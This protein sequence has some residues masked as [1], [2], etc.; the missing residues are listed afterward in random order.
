MLAPSGDSLRFQL[1]GISMYHASD[2]ASPE[3]AS[4]EEPVPRRCCHRYLVVLAATFVFVTTTTLAAQVELQDPDVAVFAKA[5]EWI[6]RH[7]EFYADHYREQTKQAIE[8][9]EKRTELLRQGKTPW[10]SQIGM[11]V[12]GYRSKVD[13]SIQPFAVTLP[14]GFDATSD[15]SWPLHVVLHGRA[16]KMN[17]VNFIHQYNDKPVS[18]ENTGWIQLDVFGRTNNAYRWSGETD[19]FEAIAKVKTLYRID[20]DRIVLRGFSMGGAGAWHLGM[21]HPHVWCSVGPGAGFVDFYKYQ[22]Q[23]KPLPTHQHATL[24]IYDSIDYALNAFNVP[25]CTYGGEND[26]QL[27]AGKSMHDAAMKLGVPMKLIVGPNMGH[28]FDPESRREFIEFHTNAMRAGRT[29]GRNR[30]EIRFT[31]RTLRY[32][33]CD[34]ISIEEQPLVYEPSLV[35][36]RQTDDTITVRT[37]NVR[38]LRIELPMADRTLAVDGQPVVPHSTSP[39]IVLEKRDGTWNR[40]DELQFEKNAATHKRH[41]LQ[42]PIDDAFMDAFV[43]VPGSQTCVPGAQACVPGSQTPWSQVHEEYSQF[44]FERF[45][46]EYDKWMRAKVVVQNDADPELL[47]QDRNII[48]FGDPGSNRMIADILDQLPIRWTKE[49]ITVGGK[50]YSTENHAVAMIY[51]NPRNPNRYVVIN[52][53]HTIHE[54]DFKNS[55]AWLFPRLGD[56]AVR[57]YSSD[58]AGGFTEETVWAANFDADWKLSD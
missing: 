31:T 40:I 23:T 16:G 2:S 45:S 49:T 46:R 33:R 38:A 34:W 28:K 21:H 55:N 42:G 54:Q 57:K 39:P 37:E 11:T 1:I 5:A 9:G 6:T 8:T 19:V 44:V 53:G 25:T 52:S 56:I 41:G 10:L 3:E 17:E 13:Q 58:D 24:R 51:P 50:V 30:K 20:E 15:R 43:C 48:L 35:H 32:N 7:D 4:P 36:A 14:T 27:A 29:H 22:K 47:A 18:D 12:R 26:A